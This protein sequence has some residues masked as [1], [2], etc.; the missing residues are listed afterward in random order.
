M[1]ISQCIFIILLWFLFLGIII[2]WQRPQERYD[3]LSQNQIQIFVLYIPKRF[4]AIKKIMKK[5]D[6]NPIYVRGLDKNKI[7]LKDSLKQGVIHTDWYKYSL[8]EDVSEKSEKKPVNT[9]RI[10]CHLGHLKILKLFLQSS[11]K[12]ALIIEDDSYISWGE[13]Y[14]RKYK[15]RTILENIPPDAQIVYLSYCHEFCDFVHTYNDIFSHAVRPLCRHFYLVSREGAKIILDNTFPMHNTGDMM[16]GN[17]IVNKILKGYLVNLKFFSISQN[18]QK[19]GVF[20]SNL[21]NNGKLSSCKKNIFHENKY[22]SIQQ[23]LNNS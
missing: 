7:T 10:A 14:D 1:N 2:Y 6:L 12:Y 21:N 11:D 16:V 18:R 20:K 19:E 8:K 4:N 22:V 17:L 13:S 3:Y 5:L 9:G 23:I 15:L